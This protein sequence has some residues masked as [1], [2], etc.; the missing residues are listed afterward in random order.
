MVRLPDKGPSDRP[1]SDD[2]PDTNN[3]LPTLAELSAEVKDLIRHIASTDVSELNIESGSMRI[4]IKRGFSAPTPVVLPAP[5]VQAG[6]VYIPTSPIIAPDPT[7]AA[8]MI[9]QNPT[10]GE[11]VAL[12]DG[13]QLIAA[14]MVGTFYAAPSPTSDPYVAE[15]DAVEPGQTVGIIEAMKMMNPIESEVE[16]TIVRILVK[17]GEAVEYGKPL[18]VVRANA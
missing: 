13:E 9:G 3:S 4:A 17:N 6:A 16:G 11:G 2:E 14:P 7:K 5:Q 15:G 8:G 1:S 10:H 12:G 18:M